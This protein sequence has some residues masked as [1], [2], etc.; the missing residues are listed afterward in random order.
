MQI[1]Y[2]YHMSRHKSFTATKTQ[3]P[4]GMNHEQ[5]TSSI[6]HE[7]TV[8]SLVASPPALPV[9]CIC[10]TINTCKLSSLSQLSVRGDRSG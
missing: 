7:P 2:D 8:A 9:I 4:E 6:T 10:I 3:Q 1:Q 5:S